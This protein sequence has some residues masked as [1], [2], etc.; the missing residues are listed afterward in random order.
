M[1]NISALTHGAIMTGVFIVLL[2]IMLFVPLINLIVLLFMPLPFMIHMMRYG[3]KSTLIV[4][5]VAS[6]V[7]LILLA[8]AVIITIMALTVGGVMGYFYAHKKG[9]FSPII[10]GALTYLANYL[11][12]LLLSL[13]L[14]DINM[15]QV[16]QQYVTDMV[17]TTE[18]ASHFLQLPLNETQLEAYRE[19]IGMVADMFPAIMILSSLLLASLNHLISRPILKRLG[20]AIEGLPPFRE[21]SFPK[22]LL[23]YYLLSLL[24]FIFNMAQQGSAIYMI[25]VNIHPIL[26]ILLYIQGLAVIAYYSHHKKWGKTLPIIAVVLTVFLASFATLVIRMIG[27]FELGLGIRKRLQS[28]EK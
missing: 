6:I 7:T 15:V 17:N 23:F 25:V 19:S 3:W 21:W 26:E 28:K 20:H 13:V 2:F 18:E 22:S 27:I 1:R 5:V 14:F 12:I 9:R 24:V 4:G 16:L 11:L 8:P 10:G